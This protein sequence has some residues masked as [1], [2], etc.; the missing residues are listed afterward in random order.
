MSGPERNTED[1]V[2]T[3]TLEEYNALSPTD[4]ERLNVDE[5]GTIGGH[6]G[7]LPTTARARMTVYVRGGGVA[8]SNPQ[9]WNALPPPEPDDVCDAGESASDDDAT[10]IAAGMEE[11]RRAQERSA[12]YRRRRQRA[13]CSSRQTENVEAA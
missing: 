7:E 5:Y 3:L 10:I 1:D 13:N 4:L 8:V 11:R 6:G 9:H 2:G 12:R